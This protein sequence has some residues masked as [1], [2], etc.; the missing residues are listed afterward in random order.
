LVTKRPNYLKKTL[1]LLLEGESLTPSAA[2]LKYLEGMSVAR[3]IENK[4]GSVSTRYQVQKLRKF[5][6]TYN[7]QILDGRVFSRLFG[8][9]GWRKGFEIDPTSMQRTYLQISKDR[10]DTEYTEIL[11][12]VTSMITSQ[13][14][15]LIAINQTIAKEE[16]P[17]D[18]M[19]LTI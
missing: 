11:A 1:N 15:E 18:L 13:Q 16:K 19:T 6:Q 14:N 7:L 10:G 8:S 9:I 3:M 4:D 2:A 12:L 17:T 5:D